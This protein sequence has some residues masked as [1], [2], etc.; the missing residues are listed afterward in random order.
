[1][2]IF[3]TEVGEGEGCKGVWKF[4]TYL[5]DLLFIFVD[6]GGGCKIDHFL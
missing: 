3:V 1:M 6:V 2:K 5:F 4:V